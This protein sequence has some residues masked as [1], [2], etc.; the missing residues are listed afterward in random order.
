MKLNNI[1]IIGLGLI[2]G[3]IAKA[4]HDKLGLCNI[5]AIDMD[6]PSLDLALKQGIITQGLPSPDSSIHSSDI[7]FLCTPVKETF[8]YILEI[9]PHIK[10]SC[11]ITDVGSTK[12]EI[13]RLVNEMPNPPCFVGG[14][15]MAGTEKSGFA[16][17]Y[18]HLFENAY[19]VLTPC[20]S[21]TEEALETMKSLVEGIGAI[22]VVMPAGEHDKATGGISH[23]PHIIASALV[24]LVR[25]Q[26]KHNGTMQTLAAGGFKDITRIASSNPVMWEN[27][28]SSNKNYILE[29]V[30]RFKKILEDFAT[31][32][33][34]DNSGEIVEFFDGARIFR[35]TISSQSQGLILQQYRLIVDVLDKPGII[36][37]ITTLLGNHQIN[38]KNINVA[39]SREYEQGCLII[40]LP[41][42]DSV[43]I[44]FDLLTAAGYKLYK[45]R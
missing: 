21:M 27:I 6:K 5:T 34:N 12:E 18:A 44:A 2:G 26:D 37:D 11:I 32:L 24:N 19:Y 3:S 42:S 36:G 22:P 23:L 16:N 1:T 40:T 38:I 31:N 25:D 9:A 7:I 35:D 33:R 43:N 4:L 28:V 17:S 41:D 45:N 8:G 10:K 14:H 39:N 30:E 29:H 13:I 20:T 15:P